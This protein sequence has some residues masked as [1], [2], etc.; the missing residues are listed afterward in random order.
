MLFDSWDAKGCVLRTYADNEHIIRNLGLAG[1]SLDIGIVIN[2]HDLPRGINLGALCFIELD[3][4][5]LMSRYTS[6]WLHDGSM[7]DGT[8]CT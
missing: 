6:D 3:G 7:L 4:S 2:E 8:G 5:F 1:S